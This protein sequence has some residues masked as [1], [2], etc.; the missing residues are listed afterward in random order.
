MTEDILDYWTRLIKTVFPENAWITSRFFKN[1]CL[2]NIDW[3]LKDDPKNPNKRS[4][5]IE[6]IIKGDTLENY[7]D[8]NKKDR[9]LSDIMLKEF[10]HKQYNYFSS[11]YEISTSQ[12]VPKEKWLI[13]GDVLNC[14]PS[15]DTSLR[16]QVKSVY[17]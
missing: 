4:K 13:S 1:D 11:N 17:Q 8:K 5:K 16:D 2:I 7:L 6:I 10:I 14:K 15:F 12:Y 9:E 3:K